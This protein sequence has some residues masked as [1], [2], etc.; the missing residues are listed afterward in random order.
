M[1]PLTPIRIIFRIQGFINELNYRH[2][3]QGDQINDEMYSKLT[4]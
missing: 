4:I 1:C 2:P 3:L